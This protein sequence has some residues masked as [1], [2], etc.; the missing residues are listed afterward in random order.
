MRRADMVKIPGGT[1]A[2]RRTLNNR[3]EIERGEITTIS[4]PRPL[5]ALIPKAAA[6]RS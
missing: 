2:L 1:Q 4:V 5:G 3:L 6:P